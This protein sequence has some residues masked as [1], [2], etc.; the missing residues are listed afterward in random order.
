MEKDD[1]QL[2]HDILA[3]DHTAFTTLVEK[4]QKSVHALA[5]R[6]IGD[7]H[8]AQEI[9]QDTFLQ[10]YQNLSTLRNPNLFAGWL[11]VIANRLCIDWLRKQKPEMQSLE[12]PRIENI[13]EKL[14]YTRYMSEQRETETA[15]HYYEIVKQLLEKLPEKERTV[16][17]LHY[18]DEMTTKEIGSFLGVSVN[19]IHSWLYRARKRLREHLQGEEF[20][21]TQEGRGELDQSTEE[22]ILKEF[23]P[24]MLG[25]IETKIHAELQG[26]LGKSIP[27]TQVLEQVLEKMMGDIKEKI[28]AEIQAQLG[29]EFPKM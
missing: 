12:D 17:T 5:W 1:V 28:L 26:Q 9:T 24:K 3:G 11:Y 29:K 6:K 8:H 15:E 19:T 25:T 16:V 18:L 20:H 13:V 22:V 27:D 14:S 23:V 4:Y 7:F 21:M 2:I 10:A